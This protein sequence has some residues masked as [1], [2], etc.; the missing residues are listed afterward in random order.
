M[1]HKRNIKI[2]L[3]LYSQTMSDPNST[4]IMVSGWVKKRL[5]EL[6]NKEGHTS[7]DSTIRVLLIR[8]TGD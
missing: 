6:K 7:L 2:A 5:E 4:N 8:Y 3:A 1:C